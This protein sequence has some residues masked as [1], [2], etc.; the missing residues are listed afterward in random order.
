MLIRLQTRLPLPLL[1]MAA[2]T[3]KWTKNRPFSFVPG[4]FTLLSCTDF[5]PTGPFQTHLQSSIHSFSLKRN[6]SKPLP[7][8]PSKSPPFS[9]IFRDLRFNRLPLL[10]ALVFL[11][12]LFGACAL[13]SACSIHILGSSRE[14]LVAE[15]SLFP[16]DPSLDPSPNP[17]TVHGI[18]GIPTES[19][20]EIN[21]IPLESNWNPTGIRSAGKC[22]KIAKGVQNTSL[23]E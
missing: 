6:P 18:R 3:Q 4:S 17:S 10:H 1:P 20:L 23:R 22:V 12:V 9:P 7:F 5:H 2:F 8:S 15:Q 14:G 19:Q 13:C 16:L 11:H 21:G